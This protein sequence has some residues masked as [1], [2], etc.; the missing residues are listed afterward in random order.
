MLLPIQRFWGF[1]AKKLIV[2]N[3]D[4][5][6]HW[7][8]LKHLN[9]LPCDLLWKLGDLFFPLC[10]EDTDSPISHSSPSLM[11]LIQL[12]QCGDRKENYMGNFSACTW[13]PKIAK[14]W[15][16]K[17][18]FGRIRNRSWPTALNPSK[19]RILL[20]SDNLWRKMQIYKKRQSSY[21]FV[22]NIFILP[23]F[24]KLKAADNTTRRCKDTK[25]QESI[26]KRETVHTLRTQPCLPREF[27]FHE[28]TTELSK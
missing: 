19:W 9:L 16:N 22:E 5:I 18:I 12:S 26:N 14:R 3:L 15:W 27:S 13:F 20:A 8:Q 10:F 24:L 6:I 2:L 17:F 1:T 25:P 11:L 4:K 21:L 28:M 7:N 23:Y